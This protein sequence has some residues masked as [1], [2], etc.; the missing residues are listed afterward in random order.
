MKGTICV[1]NTVM[2]NPTTGYMYACP[3]CNSIGWIANYPLI[4]AII[5][6]SHC[7]VELEWE[8]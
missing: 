1:S 3:D 8:A 7:G 6:C 4:G 2:A 5:Y